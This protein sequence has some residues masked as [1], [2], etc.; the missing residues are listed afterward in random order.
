MTLYTKQF[1]AVFTDLHR[2]YSRLVTAA[3]PEN[4]PDK[5]RQFDLRLNLTLGKSINYSRQFVKDK[6]GKEKEIYKQLS[7]LNDAWL[8]YD[9][10]LR[11][12][13]E[14]AMVHRTR[15][16]SISH[17]VPFSKE[18]LKR[19]E[20]E[21]IL[22]LFNS[23]ISTELISKT[24]RRRDLLNYVTYLVMNG[25]PAAVPLLKIT[26]RNIQSQSEWTFEQIIAVLYAIY[27]LYNHRCDAAKS[28]I[29][30]YVTKQNLL[31]AGF[32]VF[33]L[34]N[35]KIAIYTIQNKVL[36]K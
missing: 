25:S 30:Y 27:W 7:H 11:L 20:I 22:S 6:S 26:T 15:T 10:L 33:I 1:E 21:D 36:C 28:G 13:D 5:L 32:D 24:K 12:C 18:L 23:F 29:T 19:F 2:Q 31:S 16:G 8:A 17:M 3:L 9:V 14:F 4:I 34:F 35:L